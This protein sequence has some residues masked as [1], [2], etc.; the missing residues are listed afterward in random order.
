[1]VLDQTETI[2]KVKNYAK[3]SV[4]IKE[5]R[6]GVSVEFMRFMLIGK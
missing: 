4:E 2:I 3:I 1:M 5:G 6:V